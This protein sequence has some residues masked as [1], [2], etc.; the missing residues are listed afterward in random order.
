M[1]W[2]R[3]NTA[4]D[5]IQPTPNLLCN[6]EIQ[7]R[8]RWLSPQFLIEIVQSVLQWIWLIYHPHLG[9]LIIQICWSVWK[10]TQ[11]L[12]FSLRVNCQITKDIFGEYK[13]AMRSK[14]NCTLTEWHYTH[15]KH[16]ND[17]LNFLIQFSIKFILYA[18]AYTYFNMN[19]VKTG[20]WKTKEWKYSNKFPS[21]IVETPMKLCW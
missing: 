12:N 3:K 9:C 21:N 6:R 14:L 8:N 1:L 20:K 13:M 4:D 15:R 18:C 17:A 2:T 10:R 5:K 7:N 19:A 16:F 11:N